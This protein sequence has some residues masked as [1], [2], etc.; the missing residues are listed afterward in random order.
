MPRKKSEIGSN[1]LGLPLPLEK[2]ATTWS[3]N[4]ATKLG[5]LTTMLQSSTT[6]IANMACHV[7]TEN[8]TPVARLA[9]SFAIPGDLATFI[10][11]L[12][13]L[14]QP[15]TSQDTSPKK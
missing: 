9:I 12:W 6:Q 3:V 1:V 4:M 10:S 5:D 8:G 2:S 14:N 11:A 15:A 7:T 13:K